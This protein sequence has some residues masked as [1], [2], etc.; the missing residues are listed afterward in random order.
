VRVSPRTLLIALL[1]IKVALGLGYITQQMFWQYHE[2]DF[3]NAARHLRTTGSLPELDPNQPDSRN[4]NQ[5]PLYYITLLPFLML[6]DDGTP[7]PAGTLSPAICE[8]YNDNLTSHLT[9]PA[10]NFPGQGVV[11]AGYLMRVWSMVLACAAVGFTFAAGRVL[12]PAQSWVALAAAAFVAFEPTLVELAS[13]INNDNLIF[14]LGA[15]YIW[16]GARLFRSQ[17]SPVLNLIL[18]LGV[19]VLGILSKLSGWLMLAVALLILIGFIGSRFRHQIT[20][21]QRRILLIGTALILLGVVGLGLINVQQTGSIFGRYRQLDQLIARTLRTLNP[22][23]VTEMTIATVQDSLRYYSAPLQAQAPRAALLQAYRLLLGIGLVA[24]VWGLARAVWRRDRGLMLTFA[25]LLLWCGLNILLVLLRSILNNGNPNFVRD[26]LIFAPVRYYAPALPALAILLAAGLLAVAHTIT[27]RLPQR[28]HTAVTSAILLFIPGI[29]LLVALLWL[30]LPIAETQM[31]AQGRLTPQQFAAL[32]VT[33]VETTGTPSG[34]RILGYQ[35]QP[36]PDAGLINLTLYATTPQTPAVASQIEAVTT[37]GDNTQTC[38]AHPLRG[39]Y[40]TTRWQP[41]E[42]VAIPL[43]IPNCLPQAATSSVI[44]IRW[45]TS[46]AASSSALTIPLEH[47]AWA[48]ANRCPTS[49]GII[50]GLQVVRHNLPETLQL[51][52]TQRNLIFS[53]NWLVRDLPPNAALRA[54]QLRHVA[55]GTTYT[56]EGTPRQQSYPFNRWTTG[57]YVYF[58]ECVWLMPPDAP[59]GDYAVSIGVKDAEGALLPAVDANGQLTMDNWLPLATV[60][61]QP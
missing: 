25:L 36:N 8:G 32:T 52:D 53:V 42:V 27:P 50:S 44:D 26:F 22:R 12:F 24:M 46:D 57:E 19:S 6:A 18:L 28:I 37:T 13:E 41:D 34:L 58:D 55:S 30:R 16:L 54:Y 29:W 33:P 45:R 48:I 2:A 40:P 51:A 60:T 59:L 14:F 5:P 61:I 20:P 17:G 38:R 21:R 10:Y 47:G 56:C 4:Q 35:L 9:T 11:L 23:I 39:L 49:L 15:A 3:L 43:E 31:I 7:A 1:C